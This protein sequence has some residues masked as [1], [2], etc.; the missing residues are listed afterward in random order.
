[1]ERL[2]GRGEEVTE[3]REC[4][5][6]WSSNR[7]VSLSLMLAELHRLYRKLCTAGGLLSAE[8]LDPGPIFPG[9]GDCPGGSE[10]SYDTFW[11]RRT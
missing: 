9:S 1:M 11:K 4:L 2:I 3:A 8:T 5:G 6:E 10:R 7:D